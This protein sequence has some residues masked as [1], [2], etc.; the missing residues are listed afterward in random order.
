MNE[1]LR[2]GEEGAARALADN[3]VL[4]RGLGVS[5]RDIMVMQDALTELIRQRVP[6][7]EES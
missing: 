2:R 6:K 3:Y 1:A 7:A 4:R 5:P